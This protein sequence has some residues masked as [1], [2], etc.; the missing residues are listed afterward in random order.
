MCY[1][2]QGA[3]AAL[4]ARGARVACSQS[5]ASGPAAV[6]FLS[7]LDGRDG[8]HEDGVQGTVWTVGPLAWSLDYSVT[9]PPDVDIAKAP[10]HDGGVEGEGEGRRREEAP[11]PAFQSA[12]PFVFSPEALA[13]SSSCALGCFCCLESQGPS[14]ESCPVS[15]ERSYIVD[16]SLVQLD[17]F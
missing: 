9:L 4:L 15:S 14:V 12:A 16:E 10:S 17:S 5:H 1:S 8:A 7:G 2:S 13:R 6:G 11:E 3:G